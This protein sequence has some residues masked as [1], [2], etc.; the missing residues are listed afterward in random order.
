MEITGW[1][2]TLPR[3][4]VLSLL[5][6]LASLQLVFASP[7]KTGRSLGIANTDFIANEQMAGES[8]LHH[9]ATVPNPKTLYPAHN[10][11]VPVNHF[12]ISP[13][14]APHTDAHFDLRYWY[15]ASYYKPGGPVIVLHGGETDGEKRLE[16]LQKGIVAI[17]A[18]A[19]NGLGVVLEHRYY[20]KSVVTEDLS[21]KNLRFLTTE[22]AMADSAYFA[23][24]V[25]FEG[26]DGKDLD[27]RVGK[28]GKDQAP[29]II[30]GGSYAGAQVSFLRVEYPDLF[31]GAISSSG[32]TKAIY[33]FWEYFE[34][35]R[36][37]GPPD[38]MSTT[39]KLVH[40]VDN[41]ILGL[42]NAETT[43]KLKSLFGLGDLTH[44]DDFGFILT[45]G[46]SFWQSVNWDP[47]VSTP[48]F[49][50]YCANVTSD[51]LLHGNEEAREQAREI[52]VA[53]GYDKEAD[54]LT[55]R[56]LNLAGYVFV[57]LVVKCEGLNITLDECL[58]SHDSAWYTKDD[59]S[60]TNRLWAYQVCTEWGYFQVG[61]TVPKDQ[62]PVVSRL[63]DI[64]FASMMCRKAFGISEQPDVE[65][66][67]KY[68]GFDIEYERLAFVDGE[69]DPWRPATPHAESARPRKS[70][71][72]KPFILIEGAGHHWDENGL[73]P[74]ETTPT[75]PP[76]PVAEAQ[77]QEVEFV[78]K[79]VK[80]WHENRQKGQ[81]RKQLTLVSP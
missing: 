33:D 64:E 5:L 27:L 65:R 51:E 30:Y 71:L 13:R 76:P 19:T 22:Q 10:I 46:P 67:N 70:T 11:S 36:K 74:N 54:A 45:V 4:P 15:D 34:P 72:D 35:V 9:S 6:W 38:C 44:N 23:Q 12:P 58:G 31:W 78:K 61:S 69:V 68:G 21:A 55:N 75:L 79:W 29:W 20:G 80:D 42:N 14:Y 32:V 26:V 66:V 60:Q 73:F 18:Q 48:E 17:L 62:L 24:N 39:Q 2:A 25:V 63:V 77:K 40:I 8:N 50:Y 49:D 7:W 1:V 16:Y 28:G 56:L 37:Y 43:K 3:P 81:T 47:A 57:S 59:L 52:V 41:I 53:G